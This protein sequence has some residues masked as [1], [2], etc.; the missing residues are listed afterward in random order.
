MKK[1]FLLLGITS[2]YAAASQQKDV[3]DI[4]RHIQELQRKNIPLQGKIKSPV[5]E[6]KY[7]SLNNIFTA[8]VGKY[9]HSLSNGDKVYTLTIDNMPC[10]VPGITNNIMPNI[11]YPENYFESPLFK[12]NTPGSIPNAVKSY[13]LIITN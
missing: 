11:S 4:N 12:N 13:R 2:C 9:S 8:P 5:P 3:F 7:F 10:V 6:I 1:I